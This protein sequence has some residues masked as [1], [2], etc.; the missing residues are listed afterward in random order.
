MPLLAAL[1]SLATVKGAQAEGPV[2]LR[3]VRA[4]EA[5]RSQ[6]PKISPVKAKTIVGWDEWASA[7]EDAWVEAVRSR[8]RFDVVDMISVSRVCSSQWRQ[9]GILRC[10][11][12]VHDL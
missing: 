2:G 6:P 12:H 4:T 1:R 3:E 10:H 9:C 7:S 5:T 11:A 8:Y